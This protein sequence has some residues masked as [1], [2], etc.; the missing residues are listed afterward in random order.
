MI[1]G[2]VERDVQI[3]EKACAHRRSGHRSVLSTRE[4]P[5]EEIRAMLPTRCASQPTALVNGAVRTTRS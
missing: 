2:D 3:V 4:E 1:H 5:R